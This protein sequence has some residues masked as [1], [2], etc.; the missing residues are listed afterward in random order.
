[1]TGEEVVK[2]GG[3]ASI[4]D[5]IRFTLD[6]NPEVFTARERLASAQADLNAEENQR[7]PSISLEAVAENDD[8]DSTAYVRVLQPL[9]VGGRIDNAIQKAVIQVDLAEVQLHRTQRELM[10][11]TVIAFT[12]VTGLKERIRA[13]SK[14]IDEH[15]ELLDMISRRR[16]GKISSEADVQLA[17]SRLTQAVLTSED[18][19]GQL[20]IARN[21]LFALTRTPLDDFEPVMTEL[22]ELPGH[23][24]V[25]ADVENASPRLEQIRLE[26][27]IAKMNRLVSQSEYFPSLYG[28]LDQDIYD[29]EGTS[30]QHLDTTLA[31][32]LEGELDGAGFRT[33][34][35]VKSSE[36]LIRATQ[37]Q[38]RAERNDVNR[39]ARS[40]LADRDLERQLVDLNRSLVKSTASTL[41]SYT[42]QY[43]AGRK[44]W[45][46]LLNIQREFANARLNLELVKS[47]YEQ[48]SLRLAVQMGRFDEAAGIVK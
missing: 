3:V 45:L 10:E 34:E 20:Q 22:L 6:K 1:M 30:S 21:E 47:R 31:L 33:F 14:N 39:T 41:A 23:A 38:S 4:H 12:E 2:D 25:E 29:K 24:Q 26:I 37:M 46:D 28:R 7:M 44:S 13:A 18:L 16:T 9:W 48:A 42:R 19:K 5:T 36:V 35:Q 27:D 32:V 17:Q 43:E 15:K 8:E 11:E 40:L